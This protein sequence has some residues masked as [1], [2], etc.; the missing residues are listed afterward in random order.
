MESSSDEALA[1]GAAGLLIWNN[2][3]AQGYDKTGEPYV[4]RVKQIADQMNM[5]DGRSYCTE[6][7]KANRAK[8]IFIW[9]VY[10]WLA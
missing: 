1:T 7:S 3:G 8:A 10:S 5:Y 2:N 9:G 4:L 6:D